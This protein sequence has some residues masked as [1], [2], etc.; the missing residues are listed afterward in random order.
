MYVVDFGREVRERNRRLAFHETL[1]IRLY[2]A[3][4]HC[5]GQEKR[6]ARARGLSECR[7]IARGKRDKKKTSVSALQIVHLP[8]GEKKKG[9]LPFAVIEIGQKTSGDVEMRRQGPIARRKRG[10]KRGRGKCSRRKNGTNPPRGKESQSDGFWRSSSRCEKGEKERLRRHAT[11]PLRLPR[12]RTRSADLGQS[13][14]AY[15]V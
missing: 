5:L 6:G 2:V 3:S 11:L 4:S 15:A 7:A 14:V 9:T 10:K 8:Q 12:A 13:C 1:L